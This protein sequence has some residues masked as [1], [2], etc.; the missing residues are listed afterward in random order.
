MSRSNSK[1]LVLDAS[2]SLGSNDRKFNPIG[3]TVGDRNRKCLQA[4]WEE[5][6]VA[7]FNR[8][9]QQE[10]R[11]HASPFAVAWL[12]KMIQKSRIVVDEGNNFSPLLQ[13]ASDCLPS[14]GEKAALAKDFHLVQSALATGQLILSN[15]VRFPRYVTQACVAVPELTQLYY[16]SPHA[17]GEDCRLWIKAGADKEP[18]RRIDNWFANYQP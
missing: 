10:W 5:E 15:E 1:R 13:P 4:V 6:H 18:N 14:N 7:V 16:G 12:Q 8:Q 2:L 11:I 9:L 3:D 17:E